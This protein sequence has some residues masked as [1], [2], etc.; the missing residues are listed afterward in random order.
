MRADENSANNIA[1]HRSRAISVPTKPKRGLATNAI[2]TIETTTATAARMPIS[3]QLLLW[4][5]IRPTSMIR[6][7]RNVISGLGRL[8]V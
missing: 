3:R 5:M 7:L 4:P 2:A 6:T 8:I 1:P